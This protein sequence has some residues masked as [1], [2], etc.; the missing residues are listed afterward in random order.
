MPNLV[1]VAKVVLSEWLPE[2]TLDRLQACPASGDAN[3]AQV[4]ARLR[5]VEEGLCNPKPGNPKGRNPPARLGHH[6]EGLGHHTGNGGRS[7][8]DI[9][10]RLLTS[11]F[12]SICNHFH[13][14]VSAPE[15]A[16]PSFHGIIIYP[17]LIDPVDLVNFH[18]GKKT[19]S[20]WCPGRI[21]KNE[22]T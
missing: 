22:S 7:S 8:S 10:N 3:W 17:F 4:D 11:D 20:I 13:F 1:G 19:S 21:K 16:H 2:E 5:R 18:C 15:H 9:F 6:T 12:H 14:G